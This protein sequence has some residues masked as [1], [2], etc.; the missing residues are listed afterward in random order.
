MARR[1][2]LM[3]AHLSQLAA[4]AVVGTNSY[5]EASGAATTLLGTT[6]TDAV[7]LPADVNN[8]TGASNT[9]A[10]LPQSASP[11][12]SCFVYNSGANTIKVY[13]ATSAGKINGGSAGVAVTIA[14]LKAAEFVMVGPADNWAYVVTG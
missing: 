13:P 5:S 7:Q 3:G 6:I 8:V 9:G 1:L 14:T 10:L 12:D 2:N 11:S 4:A